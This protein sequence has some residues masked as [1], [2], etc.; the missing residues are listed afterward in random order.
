MLELKISCVDA[1][2]ARTYLNAHQYHNLL[3]D[4]YQA[5]RDAKRHGTTVDILKQV[6]VFLPHLAQAIDH[7][8]GPY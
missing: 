3:N 1:D 8:T 5:L 7:N 2:E 6:D 4:L